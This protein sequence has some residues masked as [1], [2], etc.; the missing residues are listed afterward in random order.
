MSSNNYRT[1]FNTILRTQ[2]VQSSDDQKF[3]SMQYH[4]Y[5]AISTTTNNVKKW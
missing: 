5:H 2:Y 3:R 1:I 4:R